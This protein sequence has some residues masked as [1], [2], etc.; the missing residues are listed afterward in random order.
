MAMN[1]VCEASVPAPGRLLHHPG[2]QRCSRVCPAAPMSR[3]S[4]TPL[5]WA[6]SLTLAI[7]TR[8]PRPPTWRRT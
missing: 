1:T 6:R 8:S 2:Q 3:L 5:A 4:A 7:P